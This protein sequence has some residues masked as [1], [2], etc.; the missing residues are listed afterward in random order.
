MSRIEIV[1]AVRGVIAANIPDGFVPARH[2]VGMDCWAVPPEAAP[3]QRGS[4]PL[5]VV[6]LGER[7]S[8]VSLFMMG[9]YFDPAMRT[10]FDR[11]WTDS[12][13]PLRRGKIAVQLRD[14][15]DVPLDVI[16][17][18]VQWFSVDDLVAAYERD[19]GG[20]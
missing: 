15:D 18:A 6:G 19:R 9:L 11:A 3:R 2:Y 7:K 1:H 10:W 20:I 5:V 17:E 13:C 8:Y 14:L 12:G 16:A 4:N